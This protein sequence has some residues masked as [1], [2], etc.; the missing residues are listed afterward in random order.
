MV[1]IADRAAQELVE[2]TR[3]VLV[4]SF[5]QHYGRMHP[6]GIDSAGPSG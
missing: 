6:D 2:Q 3:L 1:A 4:R 5:S